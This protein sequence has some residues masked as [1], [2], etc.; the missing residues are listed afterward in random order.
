MKRRN[1]IAGLGSA[2]VDEI[3]HD[4][5]R[6]I[7]SY[8]AFAAIS[9]AYAGCS[10][11]SSSSA[12]DVVARL[13]GHATLTARFVMRLSRVPCRL[14]ALP[15]ETPVL[16]YSPNTNSMV[17][18]R[19]SRSSGVFTSVFLAGRLSPVPKEQVLASIPPPP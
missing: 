13:P 10:C 7:T 2:A 1:F 3:K 18:L 14:A 11:R 5:Y 12:A 15:G 17:W 9:P 16:S 4:G 6:V 8:R 19:I